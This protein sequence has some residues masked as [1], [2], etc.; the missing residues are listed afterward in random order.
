MIALRVIGK[1]IQTVLTLLMAG[2]LLW[3]AYVTMGA[4][5]ILSDFMIAGGAAGL[6]VAYLELR[7]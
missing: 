1:I 5:P 3:G 7:R 6:V 4:H 2:I